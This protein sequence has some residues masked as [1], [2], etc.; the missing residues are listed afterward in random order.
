MA[1]LETTDQRISLKEV[2]ASQG[3]N[4][5]AFTL[6]SLEIGALAFVVSGVVTLVADIN[7]WPMALLVIVFSGFGAVQF[8]YL[9][10]LR[11]RSIPPSP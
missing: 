5:G 8:A 7:Q 2:L 9:L 1:G 3:R 4:Y 11:K 6:W 10:V